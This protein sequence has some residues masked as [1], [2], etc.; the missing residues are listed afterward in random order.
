MASV[1]PAPV[2]QFMP[3]IL[4]SSL[5]LSGMFY[6]QQEESTTK[7]GCLKSQKSEELNYTAA[8]A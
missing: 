7:I 1:K 6:L 8:E 2:Q 5:Q 3:S 4:A